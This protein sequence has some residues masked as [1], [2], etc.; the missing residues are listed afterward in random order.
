MSIHCICSPEGLM[1]T[2]T[3]ET[4]CLKCNSVI[5]LLCFTG[6]CILYE[7]N[8]YLFIQSIDTF[9]THVYNNHRIQSRLCANFIGCNLRV[10]QPVLRPSPEG[11]STLTGMGKK[12]STATQQHYCSHQLLTCIN[13]FK[14]FPELPVILHVPKI[15]PYVAGP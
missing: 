11:H 14:L 7:N 6:N 12:L 2:H 13:V 4:C 1:I 10:H 5:K 9:Q 3:A 8:V 15:A